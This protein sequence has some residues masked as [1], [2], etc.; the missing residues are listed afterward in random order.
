MFVLDEETNTVSPIS[1]QT[2]SALQFSE[3]N[4]LQKWILNYP[5]MLGENL[6]I[7][8]EEFD[9]WD[10]TRERLDI[11]AL[12][13]DARLVVIENKLDD[14]GRDVVWQSLKYAAYCSSLNKQEIIQIFKE[15]LGPQESGEAEE[16]IANFL[17]VPDVLET[18]LGDGSNPRIILTAAKFRKEVTATCLWLIDHEVDIQCKEITP[19]EYDGRTLLNVQQIIPPKEATEFMV[20]VGRKKLEE[21]RDRSENV[22]RHRRRIKFWEQLK[23]TLTDEAASAYSNRTGGRD[24]WWSCSTGYRG[25]THNF[26]LLKDRVRYDFN[27]ATPSTEQNKRIFDELLLKRGEIEANIGNTLQWLRLDDN[28]SSRI[29]IECELDTYDEETWPEAFEWLNAKMNMGIKTFAPLLKM[30]ET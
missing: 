9:G 14:S 25:L 2:F 12:D 10:E 30:I 22:E 11:L 16:R 4:H 26:H 19:F 5:A 29:F 7:L 20:R 15:Y 8:Q 24:H 6:L 27:I 1:Q 28:I 23:H 13:K 18:D 21:Q 17:D 3:R